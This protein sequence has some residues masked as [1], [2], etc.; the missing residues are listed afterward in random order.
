MANTKTYSVSFCLELGHFI[1]I[2]AGSPEQAQ[3]KVRKAIADDWHALL[4]K[5]ESVHFWSDVLEAT[6][7]QP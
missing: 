5:A 3:A 6:E 2:K 1:D 7:V 4:E